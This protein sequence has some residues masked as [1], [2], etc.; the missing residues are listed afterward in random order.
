MNYDLKIIEKKVANNARNILISSE[1]LISFNDNCHS[2]VLIPLLKHHSETSLLYT[3]RSN[4]MESHQ[5]QVSF[6]GGKYEKRDNSLIETALRESQEEIGINK[7]NIRVIG[8]LQPTRSTTE[9]IVF[10]VIGV[11]DHL[12]EIS[13]NSSEVDRIFCIPLNWLANPGH[14]RLKNYTSKDGA[15]RKIWFF[16]LFDGEL[17][18]GITAKITKDFIELIN[19]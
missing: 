3:R 8:Q 11:I 6:P 7:K 4:T 17:L 16:D 13:M 1:M 5:G 9:I 14:S 2:A 18:W 12:Q 19:K 15:V 10:P